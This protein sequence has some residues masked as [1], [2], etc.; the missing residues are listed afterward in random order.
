VRARNN[1]PPSCQRLGFCLL[2]Q[3]LETELTSGDRAAGDLACCLDLAPVDAR[4]RAVLVLCCRFFFTV[5]EIKEKRKEAFEK[6]KEKFTTPPV[7]RFPVYEPDC[8]FVLQTDASQVAIGGVL[9][10]ERGAEK[11]VIAYTSRQLSQAEKNYGTVERE[12]LALVFALEKFHHYI[13]DQDVL[14]LSDHKPLSWMKTAK[15]K[16]NRLQK[17]ATTLE[18]YKYT[19][20]Y[21]PGSENEAADF[22]SRLPE[23]NAITRSKTAEQH[24]K[25]E[26]E[27]KNEN[28]EI[29]I[30]ANNESKQTN[31]NPEIDIENII[32]YQESDPFTREILLN[33]KSQKSYSKNIKISPYQITSSTESGNT[34]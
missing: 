16:N 15:S 4:V 18:K 6:L 1:E 22:L 28:P 9:M 2:G 23:S 12:C 17:W 13:M 3:L 32:K 21:L 7:V 10:Q 27:S 24:S 11:W 33:H 25:K 29:E 14:V 8:K 19:I 34:N 30:E 26:N 5:Y 20:Q 31:L